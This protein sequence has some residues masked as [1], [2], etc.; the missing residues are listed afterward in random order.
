VSALPVAVLL[1]PQPICDKQ[2]PIK[3]K[4][5][6]NAS[7]CLLSL[8]PTPAPRSRAGINNPNAVQMLEPLFR[9]IGYELAEAPTVVTVSR[10]VSGPSAT[11]NGVRE[12]VGAGVTAGVM[13]QVRLTPD[14]SNPFEGITV[15]VESAEDPGDNG[16]G[17]KEEPEIANPTATGTVLDE[18]ALK[19]TSPS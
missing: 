18:L 5:R 2:P 11:D 3:T 14:G 9:M 16:L 7:S 13:A 17:D 10:A 1:F 12:Q 15:M 8:V 19:L 6:Q 4:A